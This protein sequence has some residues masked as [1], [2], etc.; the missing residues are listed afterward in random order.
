MTGHQN[1]VVS[2]SSKTSHSTGGGGGRMKKSISVGFL[3]GLDSSLTSSAVNKNTSG[4]MN[5]VT[6]IKFQFF[7]SP[8]FTPCINDFSSKIIQL[9]HY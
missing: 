3:Q 5:K 6:I 9:F 2:A 1:E 4:A 8:V 7:Q